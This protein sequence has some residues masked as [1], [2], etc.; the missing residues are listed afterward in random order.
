MN[1][2]SP[3]WAAYCA[4]MTFHL[5]ALDKNP[6]VRPMGIWETICWALSKIVMKAAG[7]QANSQ[8]CAWLED[9]IGGATHDV[10][11]M[12]RERRE[13]G[14][15]NNEEEVKDSEEETEEQIDAMMREG[16]GGG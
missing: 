9:V 6:G 7:D 13:G 5:V 2:Y 8:L 10:G 15:V 3:S 16:G 14:K 12:L 11:K 4:L 1:K